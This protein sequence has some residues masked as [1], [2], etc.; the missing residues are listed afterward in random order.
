M[1]DMEL[2]RAA[3]LRLV[4][5]AAATTLLRKQLVIIDVV[6]PFGARAPL[7]H[8]DD[9]QR[10][11]WPTR[12]TSR[13]AG[14]EVRKRAIAVTLAAEVKTHVGESLA[15][16]G[17]DASWGPAAAQ[18]PIPVITPTTGLAVSGRPGAALTLA[19]TWAQVVSIY[20][21]W[22]YEEW[23]WVGQPEVHISGP[24]LD[25]PCHKIF[26]VVTVMCGHVVA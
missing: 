12:L 7:G 26:K 17:P 16:H 3:R 20:R 18:F 11:G 10:V 22:H 23:S 19:A 5:D 8:M 14:V 13:L 25:K 6:L 9:A 2:A 21:C 1:I 24:V 15:D 4:T